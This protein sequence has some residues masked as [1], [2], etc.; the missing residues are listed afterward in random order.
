L[1]FGKGISAIGS[2]LDCAV[3]YDLIK[4]SGAWYSYNDEKIGQGRDNCR[5]YL[6]QH[7]DFSREL[8]AKLRAQIFPGRE[9]PQAKP[10]TAKQSVPKTDAVKPT[11]QVK[12][13][14]TVIKTEV[15]EKVPAYSTQPAQRGRPRK[16]EEE[17]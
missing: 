10:D 15:A 9:F 11:A 8:E 6:E 3:K 14:E 2:L 12:P 17:S 1:M 13:T 7:P 4:K 5:D 16:T